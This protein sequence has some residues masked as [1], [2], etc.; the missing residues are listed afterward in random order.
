MN[1]KNCGAPM[2]PVDGRNYLSCTYCHTFE[3]PTEL[4]D[5]DDRI[6]SLAEQADVACPVCS[7]QLSVGA[8]DQARMNYCQSCRGVLLSNEAFTHVVR[9]RRSNYQGADVTP[10]PLDPQQYQ[11]KLDCP[12]CGRKMEVH[13]YHGPGSV[14]I[15]SCSACHLIWL[16]HGELAA[17][18]RAPGQRQAATA[19]YTP[20]P[21]RPEASHPPITVQFG[22]ETK[23]DLFNLF[24]G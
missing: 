22:D 2:T 15:D 19:S 24:F 10:V 11:R 18:E 20:P 5:S 16:D 12:R 9:N 21:P 3:F 13:P 17:I 6:T 7:E 14:V 8:F 23:F 4:D 1:C